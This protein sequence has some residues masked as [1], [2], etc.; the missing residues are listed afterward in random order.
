MANRYKH[1]IYNLPEF[2]NTY[3]IVSLLHEKEEAIKQ[4]TELNDRTEEIEKDILSLVSVLWEKNE[5]DDAKAHFAE[6]LNGGYGD[7]TN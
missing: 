3:R 1:W 4:I 5:I 2:G 7:A 6:N